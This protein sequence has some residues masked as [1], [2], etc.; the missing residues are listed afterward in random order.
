LRRAQ[1]GGSACFMTRDALYRG[2]FDASARSPV[3]AQ[4]RVRRSPFHVRRPFI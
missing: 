4:K 2:C 1:H 3:A